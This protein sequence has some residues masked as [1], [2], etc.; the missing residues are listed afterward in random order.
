MTLADLRQLKKLLTLATSENDN[1][2][3][4]AW[5]A[6]TRLI[7][8][9]GATWAMVIDKQVQVVDPSGLDMVSD[10]LDSFVFERAFAAARGE[11]RAKISSIRA[12]WSRGE[13]LTERQ[14]AFVLAAVPR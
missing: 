7:A 1:E 4:S 5:R 2:A 6:A 13:A 11:Q 14:R 12:Q 3:L 10:G 9:D 8:R